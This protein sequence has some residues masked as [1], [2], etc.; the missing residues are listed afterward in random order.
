L[1]P[2]SDVDMSERSK[3]RRA[4]SKARREKARDETFKKIR[5]G[6]S[7][8][9]L[10]IGGKFHSMGM[11]NIFPPVKPGEFKK[12]ANKAKIKMQPDASKRRD[13][14]KTGRIPT[15][16]GKNALKPFSD[17]WSPQLQGFFNKRNLI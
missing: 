14:K 9:G 6:D 4:A 11:D 16:R 7:D 2:L 5:R 1:E 3:K 8:A 13:K 10:Y 17:G 12:K 15:I